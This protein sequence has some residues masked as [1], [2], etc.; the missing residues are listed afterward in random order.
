MGGGVFLTIL[1]AQL[2]GALPRCAG[3]SL[4]VGLAAIAC[5]S[6]AHVGT[7]Q[8]IETVV[9]P[10]LKALYNATDG[11]NWTN[12]T[13]NNQPWDVTSVPTAAELNAWYGVTYDTGKL[14][15][16]DLG[17]NELSG[18]IPD[19]IGNLTALV[20]LSLDENTITG[21]IPD[22]LGNLTNLELLEIHTSNV[23]GEIP[24]ALGKLTNL[25][26]LSLSDNDLT[27]SLPAKLGDIS[28]L[29]LLQVAKNKLT[30][31]LPSNLTNL[32]NM[33]LFD[34]RDND[35]LCA[36]TDDDFQDWL[37]SFV[38]S[39]LG[40][41]PNCKALELPEIEDK[42]YITG[43]NVPGDALPAPKYGITP[44]ASIT[45]MP[46]L[47]SGLTISSDS[48]ISGTPT[49]VFPRT[50][51]TYTV[52]DAAM[53]SASQTFD[54][55]VVEGLTLPTVP[56]L[57]LEYDI[58]HSSVLPEA[59]GGTPP[60]T[61][62]LTPPLPSDLGLT[63]D[64]D[65]RTLSGTPEEATGETTYTYTVT[66][67]GGL[68]SPQ[69]FTIEVLLGL[70]AI[71]DGVF[72]AGVPISP[73]ELPEAMGGTGQVTYTL[74]PAV[75]E[76]LEFD[77][78]AR[79]LSGTP[80]AGQAPIIYIYTATDAATPALT[81]ARTFTIEV[82][83]GLAEIADQT[84]EYG[85]AIPNLVLPAVVGAT[86]TVT[87]TLTPAEPPGLTFVANT[88]TLSGTP[89]AAT[90]LTEYTYTATDDA[91][92]AL[93]RSRTFTIEVLLGLA[94]IGDEVFDAGVPISP[95]ELPA[96]MGGTTPYTYTLTPAVPAGL[97]FDDNTRILS[98]TPTAGQASTEYTYTATDAATSALTRARTFTMEVALGLAAI[99]DQRYEY[100]EAI[101]DLVLP[102]VVG[103]TGTVTY[104]LTPAEPP[105]LVFDASTRTL[106]GTPTAATGAT[107]YTYTAAD[108]G[109]QD[110][111]RTF[112][113]E[114]LLALAAI[115]DE[116]FATNVPISPVEL[117]EALGGTPPVAYVLE[118]GLPAGLGFDPAT[119]ILSG[120]PTEGL[121]PTDYTYRATD[122][123]GLTRTRAFIMEVTLSLAEIPDQAYEY[124]EAIP[125]LV[126]PEVAGAPGAFTYTLTP[127]PP[128]GLN[129]DQNTRTL[130][131][132]PEAATVVTTYE[133]TA[134]DAAA[135]LTGSQIFAMEV[136]LALDDDIGEEVVFTTND[137][138]SPL[139]FPE[140]LGGT[141]PYTYALTPDP[142]AGLVFDAT[143]RVLSGTPTAVTAPAPYTYEATDGAGLTRSRVFTI[144]VVTAGLFLR[145]VPEQVYMFGEVVSFLL[146][147]ARGG[148]PPHR[149]TLTPDLPEGLV[150]NEN[151]RELS[152][153]PT[154][155]V[156]RQEYTYTVTDSVQATVPVTFGIEVTLAWAEVPDRT[157]TFDV[158]IVPLELTEPLGGTAPYEYTVSPDPPPGLAFQAGSLTGTPLVGV[159]RTEYTWG[160]RDA[161]G[162]VVERSS[163][164]EVRLALA[165]LQD[166][167]FPLGVEI[168]PLVFP[169]AQGG[170]G[171]VTY[172]L[173][174]ALPQGL[175]FDE[176][177]RV[178]SG[179][180]T[181]AMGE[182]V[183][184]YRAE[185]AV[186]ALGE[187]TFS[188]EV[189]SL[190]L[191]FVENQ[192]FV[193]G[194]AVD[195]V[196]PPAVGGTPPLVYTL[197]GAL[198]EGLEF[199]DFTQRLHGV[200]TAVADVQDYVY[201]VVDGEGLTAQ[202]PF[203][204]AV[205]LAAE[206]RLPPVAA[207]HY[208][209]GREMS[210][211]LPEAAGGTDPYDYTL[212]PGPPAG[213]GFD[214]DTRTLSGT[215]VLAMP[216]AEYRYGV[217]DAEG[218]TT[219][220]AFVME[221]HGA[222]TLPSVSDQ[223]FAVGVARSVV[224]PAASG[225]LGLPTYMLTP[226]LPSGLTFDASS[227][228][229]SG[230]PT[231]VA[232]P[233]TYT[234]VATDTTGTPVEREFVLAVYDALTLPEV[235]DQRYVYGEQ[236]AWALP[237]AVGGTAP[238][239]YSLSPDPPDGLTFVAATRVLSG[240]PT[241]ATGAV[242][243]TYEA[244]DAD[245]ETAS[246]TFYIEV[247]LA[248]ASID[249]QKYR[250]GEAASLVLPAALGGADPTYMLTP[251]LPLGLTFDAATRTLGGTPMEATAP[252]EYAYVATDANG[253]A[254]SDTFL[255]EVA[256]ALASVEDREYEVGVMASDV[257]PAARGGT[258][259]YT[260]VLTPALPLGLTFDAATRVL[261]GTPTEATAPE[262]YT[263]VATDANGLAVSDT[264]LIEVRLALASIADQAYAVGEDTSLVLPA[265]LGGTDPYRY[266]LTPDLPVGL[267]FDRT[268]RVLS[269]TP[270][271]AAAPVEYTYAA[272]D[273]AGLA[274]SD[275][276]LIEVY[277]ALMLPV[278]EDQVFGVGQQVTLVLPA[279]A[280]GQRPHAYRLDLDPPDGLAFEAST[281]TLSGVPTA[282]MAAAGYTYTVEDASGRQA[283]Q[284]FSIEV[285]G[286][287]LLPAVPDQVFTVD[288]DI[289]PW[290]LPV[291]TGGRSPYEYVLHPDPPAGL[292]YDEASRTLSGRPVT[293]L[294]PQP[295]TYTVTDALGM[296]AAR[297]FTLT[298][299][300]P[301]ALLADRAALMALY[302][303][304]G[305]ERWTD[306][307][308]WLDPPA[309]VVA[310]TAEALEAWF[311]VAVDSGRVVALTLPHN[312]VE[313]TLPEA[314][315][316]LTAL[317]QLHLYGNRL[318]G[319]IPAA[320]GRLDS[321]RGLLLHDNALAG[322]IP[323]SLGRL[324]AL[325]Q[326]HLH[327]NELTGSIPD[328]LGRLVHLRELWLYGNALGGSL[329]TTLGQLDSLRGLLLHGNALVGTI[330]PAL[331]DLVR[332][333][334]LWLQ[335]NRLE[336]SI[337]P[338]L[339]QLD[340]LRTLLLHGNALTGTIPPALGDLVRL[341]DLWLQHNGLEGSIPSA[342]GQLDR[343]RGLLLHGN[344]LVGTI[345][346]V[347]GDLSALRWL[348]LQHNALEGGVP[349]ALGQLAHLER[350]QLEGNRLTGALP[351]S[352]GELAA[353][354]H[355]YVHDN[356][357]TGM[358]PQALRQL[359]ALQELFFGGADQALCAPVD[360]PYRAWLAS[361]EAVRG[362]HCGEHGLVFAA[363]VPD[364]A[365]TAGERV[366]DVALPPAEGGTAPYRY[367]LDPALPTGLAYEADARVLRGVPVAS[368][369]PV[370]Y[371]YTAMD[372]T[373]RTGQ[374]SFTLAVAPP[375]TD[376]LLLHGNYPNPFRDYTH[377]EISLAHDADVRLAVFD[378]LGRRVVDQA[379]G[380]LPAGAHRRLA[381]QVPDS[382]P[383]IYLYRVV[384]TM[385]D[386]TIVRTGHLTVVR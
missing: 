259:P 127:P 111:S 250:V 35:G 131:G 293:I 342:L 140:A 87:Y 62:A 275:T 280:G 17:N 209:V 172:T 351:D 14:T 149:Y 214:G 357:L 47:P 203:T 147:E 122:A 26:A 341:E 71:G 330:P 303:D 53:E 234:Y 116:V 27:G 260:Y 208:V 230:T 174:P 112:T 49:A 261:G 178:L 151:T 135:G 98:G 117:P 169:L 219:S 193:V 204:I 248:L 287:L 253:L 54:I 1:S 55:E 332:L 212:V 301:A 159:P 101:P 378:L 183:Y 121:A 48:I 238:Y 130:S 202:A 279:A 360:A 13:A 180:P 375:M 154:E 44:Y 374:L 9:F 184:T 309:D 78:T 120:T 222:F 162:F 288:E 251:A 173:T 277:S 11:D 64:G 39:F 347:L 76:G 270:T 22:T 73:V 227:R 177:A 19:K 104:S 237:P 133:Y 152:G 336:G 199:E 316:D 63:F 114:V 346:P 228:V 3:C 322:T 51:F 284:P 381:I 255:I 317:E 79:T 258:D 83:L 267:V 196:L 358:L 201:G 67:D 319:R 164:M 213:L 52:T 28:T 195:W 171:Q 155:V 175:H 194:E 21:S 24:A 352:L 163:F 56:S 189:L 220:Q 337:P 321:L 356:M 94:A 282:V 231:A 364:L 109:G 144:E 218:D 297:T 31:A 215:P 5:L 363:S 353:L 141:A 198:P 385:P 8:D 359:T 292:V 106:R 338:T 328:S 257:L 6:A 59:T 74:T 161:A 29:S 146:P 286:S 226:A 134:T 150:F 125:D 18:S 254:A 100:D 294:L 143:T 12:T 296:E 30:G 350:L 97:G 188:M 289:V 334:D 148:V 99:A 138:I 115:G 216:R 236:I 285:L 207:Q 33:F 170:T 70:A 160:A 210:E 84:Y 307:S 242:A 311:G 41:G 268:T 75:P 376:G 23:T 179:T 256:L 379:L 34:W 93:T 192:V 65:M 85:E 157:Y 165:A 354:T 40:G 263:Y 139:E 327:N 380:R 46:D 340:R 197:D 4:R 344:A 43:V 233:R 368:T 89:T 333:E 281:R 107:T 124:G 118:P 326:L 308:G 72:D 90:A 377:V 15:H 325:E 295:Y 361:L 69:T 224:L 153:I 291:A 92:P 365:L 247:A 61:Y 329:P 25:Q 103:A 95:V 45:L 348:Q 315:G 108:D 271:V 367:V 176:F 272:T 129:F 384:A 156:A 187:Q 324:A 66:D 246:D 82:A 310:F 252:V 265:A 240:T 239:T 225:G 102:E 80:T 278:V 68:T 205:V 110:V 305:G 158:P 383:G 128:S 264:F 211:V 221:I 232:A 86:G 302:E 10:A 320:L 185:D 266:A 362:P 190:V 269:G 166:Y 42:E 145:E 113:I 306:R 58:A 119:R 298:V 339:G 313:G 349:S 137:L 57:L 314:L 60:Y 191:P 366:A 123:A 244:T 16:L 243:Y 235:A 300:A 369:A 386:E 382:V 229:L 91:T 105:G 304:A 373:G 323:S 126:L 181:E 335:D 370:T 331:G 77:A 299:G 223:D 81:R 182:T 96:A 318:Q 20:E 167:S 249:D 290:E 245:G 312:N 50:E 345:P 37:D 36:P 283:S 262:E 142:P 32:T 136:L 206:L 186:G 200:P 2:R 371:T 372:A 274:A 273:A 88:R 168:V 217:E 343:L 132:T 276:F 355:L 241:E 7:A 38:S